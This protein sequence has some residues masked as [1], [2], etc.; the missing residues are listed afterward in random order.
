MLRVAL[1]PVVLGFVAQK[2]CD[3]PPPPEPKVELFE[4]TPT[5]VCPG[6]MVTVTWKVSGGLAAMFESNQ[7]VV[8]LHQDGALDELLL[9]EPEG[10]K[11]MQ[12]HKHTS[13]K[14]TSF[15]NNQK[16]AESEGIL[17]SVVDGTGHVGL[18]FPSCVGGGWGGDSST[19]DWTKDAL[20]TNVVSD[21]LD[22]PIVVTHAG[23]S[24]SLAE[25]DGTQNI[26]DG[27]A[28][29]GLWTASAELKAGEGCGTGPA[30]E[31]SNP[32]P[33]K[34]NNLVARVEYACP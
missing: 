33:I 5:K 2:S 24:F 7:D 32:V 4:I 22:R 16:H 20:V 31:G 8:Q 27:M 13:F 6:G 18:T 1:I 15:L 3:P 34:P 17:V 29:S 21:V 28:L 19:G 23:H 12:I 14:L 25:G 30:V 9:G 10:S 11:Q 26:P